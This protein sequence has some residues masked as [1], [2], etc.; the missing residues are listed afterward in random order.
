MSDIKYKCS[1]KDGKL[2]KNIPTL[3]FGTIIYV[4]F[5]YI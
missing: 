1:R 2:Y 5:D 4:A 3:K